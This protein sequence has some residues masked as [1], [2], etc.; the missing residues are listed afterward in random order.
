MVNVVTNMSVEVLKVHPR[1]EEFFDDISGEKYEQFKKSIQEDGIITPITVAPDMTIISGHQ[2]YKAARDLGIKLV[3]VI[4]QENL[5]DETT[6]LKT[7]LAANFGREKNNES[8]QR[9][10]IAEYVELCGYKNGGDRQAQAQTGLVVSLEE[11]A[12]QLGTSKTNLKRALS[13]ERNLTDSMKELL[14]NGTITK[15]LASDVISSLSKQEQEQLVSQLDVTQQYTKKQVQKYID[16]I[17]QLESDNP[18]IEQLKEQ[19]SELHAEKNMLERKVRLNQEEADRYNKLKSDIE[20]LSKQKNDIGRQIES[21]TE[22]S[23]LTVRLQKLLEDELAPIK[24]KRC[25]EEL[26]KSDICYSNLM[27]IVDK[28]DDW[29]NEMKRILGNTADYIIDAQ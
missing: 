2:R 19:I 8:K 18:Q 27:E 5:T 25:M 16:K 12:K 1:N 26:D 22:L 21:A 4:I 24:F 29:S 17:K 7:L 13:I 20:F 11:I 6:K 23:G 14:N 10:V 15:T 9:K 3:P 28:I